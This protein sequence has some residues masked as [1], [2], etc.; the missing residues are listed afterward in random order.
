MYEEGAPHLRREVWEELRRRCIPVL[1]ICYGMQELVH[2][3][4]GRVVGEGSR[5]FG[6]TAVSLSPEA[7]STAVASAEEGLVEAERVAREAAALAKASGEAWMVPA[8]FGPPATGADLFYGVGSEV[9]EVWMSHGDKVEDLPRE[10]Q[11][12]QA[13]KA[14]GREGGGAAARGA[15][16][17]RY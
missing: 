13:R 17:L 12:G 10:F 15:E 7:A 1:G 6:K 8:K 16:A 11:V 3:H 5:E 4:G 2:L 14:L 9:V